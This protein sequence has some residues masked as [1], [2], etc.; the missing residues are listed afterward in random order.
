MKHAGAPFVHRRSH[1]PLETRKNHHELLLQEDAL[2]F[3]CKHLF[4]PSNVTSAACLFATSEGRLSRSSIGFFP[5]DMPSSQYRELWYATN[6]NPSASAARASASTELTCTAHFTDW[7][8]AGGGGGLYSAAP[9]R[10]AP[11]DPYRH[12]RH[13]QNAPCAAGRHGP[14]G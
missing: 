1:E 13:R 4:T 3:Q 7:T 2:S 8:G 10:S 9:S 14:P 5:T 11:R 12:R 6:K